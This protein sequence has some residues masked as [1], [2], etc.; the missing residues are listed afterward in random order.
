MALQLTLQAQLEPTLTSLSTALSLAWPLAFLG[1]KTEIHIVLTQSSDKLEEE[2]LE[3]CEYNL[4]LVNFGQR[5]I[6][7]SKG[8]GMIQFSNDYM[9]VS[10]IVGE[11]TSLHGSLV[12]VASLEA[13]IG[14]WIW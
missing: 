10:Q 11:G 8:K 7:L 1:V 4:Y 14:G 12:F 3:K 5:M 2:L 13:P 9:G 6:N